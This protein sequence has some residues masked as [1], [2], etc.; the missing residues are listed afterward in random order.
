MHK[1]FHCT[2]MWIHLHYG[3]IPPAPI[4]YS[5]SSY[6]P[7]FPCITH[8]SSP[9]YSVGPVQLHPA[10]PLSYKPLTLH[11]LS[12]HTHPALT[13]TAEGGE[14]AVWRGKKEVI[15]YCH[16]VFIIRS[17]QWAGSDDHKQIIRIIINRYSVR[18]QVVVD[19]TMCLDLTAA[20]QVQLSPLK[21]TPEV[22]FLV[23]C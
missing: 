16:V 1:V 19:L 23:L 3:K 22:Q 10:P 8:F 2:Y 4:F 7:F 20:L 17:C 6:T 9:I 5:P 11:L 14:E 12:S 18:V 15:A 13:F 21:S